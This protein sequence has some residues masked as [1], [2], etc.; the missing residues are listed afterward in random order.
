[1][2]RWIDPCGEQIRRID[3]ML[4]RESFRSAVYYDVYIDGLYLV[5]LCIAPVTILIFMNVRLVQAIRS[6]AVSPAVI[7]SK[8]FSPAPR[9]KLY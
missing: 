8:T 3:V 4:Y 2:V 7:V 5:F 9:T 6:A 1:V